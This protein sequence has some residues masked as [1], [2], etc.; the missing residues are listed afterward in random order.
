MSTNAVPVTVA[1]DP[2]HHAYEVSAGLVPLAG[3]APTFVKAGTAGADIA[4]MPLADY[5][6]RRLA[7]DLSVTAVPVFLARS[8]IHS[9][10]HV[11]PE[12]LSGDEA[13]GAATAAIYARAVLQEHGGI[14][15]AVVI[16]PPGSRSAHA[17]VRPLFDR[18]AEIERR[19]YARSGVYPILSVLTIK[20]ELVARER[21]LA[22]NV[23]RSFEISRRRYF[24]R[25]QDI[26]GS[27]V[28]IPSVAGH[29]RELVS[30]F[31]RDLCPYGLAPNL[32][33]LQAFLAAAADQGVIESAPADVAELFASVEPFVDFT[34][35]I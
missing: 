3:M 14:P 5:A 19:H 18:P 8:F 22:S 25:L 26:R 23:F 27:R 12:D 29:L 4:D 33:T 1:M 31:G 21:W 34:D 9:W 20:T 16:A 10:I 35:G 28:P 15:G 17:G 6:A 24:G 7:G 2:Y 13:D 32:R 30:V 11:A